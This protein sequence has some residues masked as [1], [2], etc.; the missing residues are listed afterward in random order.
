[1]NKFKLLY[2]FF[3]FLT[4]LLSNI[5]IINAEYG[6][7]KEKKGFKEID[8]NNDKKVSYYEFQQIRQR[9]FDRLD[10][11]ND[12]IVTQKEFELRNQKFFSEIDEN[13]DKHLTKIEMFK[14]RK[15]MRN[16]LE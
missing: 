15:K 13:K 7:E 5:S 3:I 9:R 6:T 16:I 12:K 8:L 10:L 11:N 14:K 1:M 2:S 4:F